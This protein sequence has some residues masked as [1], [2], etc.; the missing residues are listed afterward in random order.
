MSGYTRSVVIEAV[1][2]QRPTGY[3]LTSSCARLRT[4]FALTH[5]IVSPYICGDRKTR[6]SGREYWVI[7][8]NL[9]AT[10]VRR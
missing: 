9:S 7:R 10:A 2:E 6:W 8:W 4:A 1:V 5:R 3:H